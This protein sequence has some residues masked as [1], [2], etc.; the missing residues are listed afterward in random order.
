MDHILYIPKYFEH[1]KEWGF[2]G[3]DHPDLFGRD[4]PLH[5]EYCAG[6][7]A[8][9][10]E[11]A[12]AHPEINWIAVEKRFERVRKIWSKIRNFQLKN[13]FVVCGEAL[14][15][16]TH[17]LPPDC[18]DAAYV[19]FPDPWP[20]EKHA[21]NRLLQE[22]FFSEMARVCKRGS[23]VT[24]VTD[25]QGYATQVTE[26]M[27]Q[28]PQWESAFAPPHYVTEWKNYGASYFGD[29]WQQMGLTI[30]Y[31]QFRCR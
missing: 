16:T 22:P 3:W 14:T 2:P 9:I 17:Y 7:G 13:L 27:S 15:Y 5:L 20:K 12:L 24:I 25:H 6:N 10:L 4:A 1:Q 29:L 26:S 31:M 18:L 8:W 19:N 21:K 28:H 23:E 11:K 30:Y